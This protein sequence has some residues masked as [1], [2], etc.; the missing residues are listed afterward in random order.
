VQRVRWELTLQSTLSSA[1]ADS[2]ASHNE[3]QAY[4]CPSTPTQL[5]AVH[6]GT[7]RHLHYC[8]EMD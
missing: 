3:S 8:L 7:T 6:D 1:D 4:R 5:I 2:I